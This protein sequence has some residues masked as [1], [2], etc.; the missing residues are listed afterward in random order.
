MTT[1]KASMNR[2]PTPWARST[3]PLL[4]GHRGAPLQ[5][6]ENTEAALDGAAA[7]GLDG[8]ETDLQRTRDGWLVVHHDPI[9]RDGQIIAFLSRKEAL[10]ADS[11]LLDID[12]LRQFLEKH[13]AALLNLEVK[14]SAPLG[15]TRAEETAATLSTWPEELLERIWISSF[16]PLL[17]L[18]LAAAEVPV[19]LAF[20][21]RDMS[22]LALLPVLPVVAVHPRHELV[23]P[24][25]V[26][27][28]H[29]RG[30]GVFTWAVNDPEL[31][32]SLL[33]IGVDG[34]IGGNPALLLEA[35]GR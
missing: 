9:L 1:S 23:T 32:R 33:A 16:D 15:D 5:A 11:D 26:R 7:A 14:T 30:L 34:L 13:P 22:A 20:L 12:Q 6:R 18:Q 25:L 10:E 21:V 28:W 4:I 24:E 2:T 8:V 19:P 35:A 31:A 27:D 17:L 3:G 29:G